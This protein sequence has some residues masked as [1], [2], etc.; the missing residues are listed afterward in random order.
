LGKSLYKK[1]YKIS[2]V[3][4]QSET[5]AT[6]LAKELNAEPITDFSLI[7]TDSPFYFICIKDDAIRASVKKIPA[8]KGIVVHTSGSIPL[9]VLKKSFE[10][11]GVLYPVQTFNKQIKNIPFNTIPLCIEGGNE[12]SLKSILGLANELSENVQQ[13]NSKQRKTIHLAAVFSCNF[14]NHLFNI[15][16]DLLKKEDLDLSLLHPLIEETVA[17]IKSNSPSKVQTGPAVRNDIEIIGE[18]LNLLENQKNYQEIYRL[19]SQN[20]LNSHKK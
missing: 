10:N 4:S 7:K 16:D 19:L 18:H 1:G 3:Y 15:A 9:S 13:I 14:V 12:F 2:Q 8:L 20:I 11:C 5:S 6:T 17:K